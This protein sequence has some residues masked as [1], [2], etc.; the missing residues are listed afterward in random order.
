MNKKFYTIIKTV[1]VSVLVAGSATSCLEKYP[2][3]AI[4]ESDAMQTFEDADQ[5]VIGIYSSLKSSALY[6]GLLTLLP[7]I[8]TDLAMASLT[9]TNPYPDIWEWTFRPTNSNIEAVYGSLYSVIGNCNFYLEKIGNVVKN[10]TDD[11]RLDLL[12]AYTGEVYAIRAL[13]YSEL[14][15]CFCEDYPSVEGGNGATPD[16]D[17]A[18]TIPGVVL[19]T[20]YSEE[21]PVVRASLYDSYDQVLRDLDNA[22]RLL[23]DGDGDPESNDGDVSDNYY[24]SQAA[25]YAIHARVALYMR[26]WDDAVK[27]STYVI[28]NE[29]FA[30]SGTQTNTATGYPAFDSLWYFDTGSELLW[31]IGFTPTS[32]GGAI[33]SVF[34]NY[35]RDYT[36]FYPD[37]VP[38]EW[39]VNLY[40]Q[41]DFRN[42]AYFADSSI[43][44]IENGYSYN[45]PVPLVVKYY[46]NRSFTSSY[47]LYHVCMPK[48]LRLAEQYL[49]RA[50]AYC[51][52]GSTGLAS[53][54][55]TT[56]SESRGAGSVS[57]GSNWVET[58]SEQRVKEL[59]MEGFR[60]HDLKRW[61]KGFER[62]PNNYTQVAGN[63]LKVE[64]DDHRFV[65]PMPQNEIEAP[66]SGIVQNNGY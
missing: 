28:N 61:H 39:V 14:I 10:E 41:Q 49:I 56:L 31:R 57:V 50:E 2:G 46:G 40:S 63:D 34:L 25:A 45:I 32:Y 13:C 51:Q 29:A 65:W 52:K 54:D 20:K 59:Y 15:K 36:Y 16:H 6:S 58:I 37:Y 7:D 22:E 62:T 33:G 9:N 35:G 38:S 42:M 17:A 64:A 1:A 48:P 8:Q 60:L 21:E 27:Y 55:L 66:G 5:H 19:R 3:S 11:A 24:I 30:L 12:D 43:T 53:N 47:M 44:G 18:K 23:D 26:N 4:P